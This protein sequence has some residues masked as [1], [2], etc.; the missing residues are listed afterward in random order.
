M[1]QQWHLTTTTA[2]ASLSFGPVILLLKTILA[3]QKLDTPYHGGLGSY[4]LYVLVA[5]HIERHLSLGG[6][7]APGEIFLSFLYR[8]GKINPRSATHTRLSQYDPIRTVSGDAEADLSN[9]FL[10]DHCVDLFAMC[11]MRLHSRLEDL[12]RESMQGGQSKKQKKARNGYPC[13]SALVVVID[14]LKLSTAREEYR[15]R[16]RHA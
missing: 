8:F 14:S 9:V 3:Q 7:D 1:Q 15:R 11:W 12:L 5:Y 4:K 13:S 6:R 16:T 2:S 10:L